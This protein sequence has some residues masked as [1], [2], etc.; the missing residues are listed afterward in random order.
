MLLS[1]GI[2]HEINEIQSMTSV[3]YMICLAF[4]GLLFQALIKWTV[5]VV[6]C[7]YQTVIQ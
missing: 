4:D 1:H 6:S 7:L 2:Q 3:I 5:M